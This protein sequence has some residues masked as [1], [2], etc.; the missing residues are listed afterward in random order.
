MAVVN[1]AERSRGPRE[2]VVRMEG[3][4]HQG[5]SHGGLKTFGSR[6]VVEV[7]AP[8]V[9][10]CGPRVLAGSLW[11]CERGPS[12]DVAPLG[13]VGGMS[14]GLGARVGISALPP[15]SCGTSNK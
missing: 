14:V 7:S 10:R 1:G 6:G 12:P 4:G 13:W 9:R 8:A 15:S 3:K 5:F 2:V 11:T